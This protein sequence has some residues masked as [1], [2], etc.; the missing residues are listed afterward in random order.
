MGS[1][2]L[3]LQPAAPAPPLTTWRVAITRASPR[4]PEWSSRACEGP[5]A[6]KPAPSARCSAHWTQRPARYHPD[7]PPSEA[8]GP[9]PGLLTLWAPLTHLPGRLTLLCAVDKAG[10]G[11]HLPTKLHRDAVGAYQLSCVR[12]LRSLTVSC[13]EAVSLAGGSRCSPYLLSS[14]GQWGQPETSWPETVRE[15][16]LW[17]QQGP[18]LGEPGRLPV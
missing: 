9:Q 15:G 5:S 2:L 1:C 6:M 4:R 13:P 10:H 12:W 7:P 14:L 3:P 11:P 17:G 8:R 16:S 18:P